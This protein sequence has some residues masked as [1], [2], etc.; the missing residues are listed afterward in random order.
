VVVWGGV[1]VA[2][3]SDGGVG[4]GET[5]GEGLD[6]G[7]TLGVTDVG[8]GVAVR[9]GGVWFSPQAAR[10]RMATARKVSLSQ[11]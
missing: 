8:E 5:A 3:A 1:G 10:T 11:K 7:V 6:G 9:R 2:L 4:E